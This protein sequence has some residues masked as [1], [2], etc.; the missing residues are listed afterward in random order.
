MSLACD[1]V[2]SSLLFFD[3]SRPSRRFTFCSLQ[4]MGPPF[5]LHW[6]VSIVLLLILNPNLNAF[7]AAFMCKSA[8][9][10]HLRHISQQRIIICLFLWAYLPLLVC[11][12]HPHSA[13]VVLC[14]EAVAMQT[15]HA[16]MA[17]STAPGCC[18]AEMR[19][20]G[21]TQYD[22]AA[23][24]RL[25]LLMESMWQS[26]MVTGGAAAADCCRLLQSNRIPKIL[27]VMLV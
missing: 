19:Q 11:M 20:H 6:W 1:E 24:G 9:I 14:R 15:I 4:S 10:H 27:M 5:F 21:L 3:A 22:C 25:R 7:K 2:R 18:R 26:K 16:S 8:V 23:S 17:G 12:L 13:A